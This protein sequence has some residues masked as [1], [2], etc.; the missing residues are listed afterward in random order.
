MV[1]LTPQENGS[2]GGKMRTRE[3][4]VG[5]NQVRV[6]TEAQVRELLET[7]PHVMA[8][9]RRVLSAQAHRAATGE[10]T[11]AEPETTESSTGTIA[12]ARGYDCGSA[13]GTRCGSGCGASDGA[14]T[15]AKVS[16][17][18]AGH[19]GLYGSPDVQLA[20]LALA[21][22]PYTENTITLL[23]AETAQRLKP[24]IQVPSKE[25]KQQ[26]APAC[27][28]HHACTDGRVKDRMLAVSAFL[29]FW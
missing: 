15:V 3:S 28:A 24:V 27:N 4:G 8:A 7:L 26:H 29:F 12:K 17:K 18:G 22:L 14:K 2:A 20:L 1:R 10:T 13:S 25:N 9:V 16:P 23:G 19:E 5:D 6:H 11:N 21:V